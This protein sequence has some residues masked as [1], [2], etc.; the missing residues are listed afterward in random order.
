V[1][2]QGHVAGG[3]DEGRRLGVGRQGPG[4]G[5]RRQRR[6]RQAHQR[7][8]QEGGARAPGAG[9]RCC[10]QEGRAE[11]TG[12]PRHRARVPAVLLPL[13]GAAAC[14]PRLRVP[15]HRVRVRVPVPVSQ[16]LLHNVET[17]V[18][19]FMYS[20]RLMPE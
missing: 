16:H 6:F 10:R 2:V 3:Q 5:G 20:N 9:R 8:A 1:P 18:Q 14:D 19:Q 15:R 4:S 13:P 17:A 11:E 12:R 7:A